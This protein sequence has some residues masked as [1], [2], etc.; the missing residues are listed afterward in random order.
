MMRLF[1]ALPFATPVKQRLGEI[2]AD[3]KQFDEPVRWVK[4]E[5]MHLT[6]RF[7]GDTE[8]RLLPRLRELITTL[9]PRYQ[10]VEASFSALGAFPN[11]RR[12]RVIWVGLSGLPD[13]LYELGDE[14]EQAVRKLGFEPEHRRFKP[15]V[16][17]GRVKRDR[18]LRV[19][20]DEIER[21]AMSPLAVRLDRLTLFQSTLTPDG[22]IYK[23]LETSV[24]GGA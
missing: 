10:P 5:N 14:I 13:Y 17:L 18:R 24:L 21:Y 2:I 15:H 1:I 11:P 6:L 9:A 12:A 19:L 8:E 23:A 4:A 7:L 16:T 20:P 22:P 3:L